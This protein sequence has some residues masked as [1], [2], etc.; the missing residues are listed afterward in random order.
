[1]PVPPASPGAS[2]A[3]VASH[4]GT[5]CWPVNETPSRRNS[6]PSRAWVADTLSGGP[7]SRQAFAASPGD[8]PMPG[9]MYRNQVWCPY[10]G[11][12]VVLC[13][14]MCGQM[15]YVNRRAQLVAAKLSSQPDSQDPQVQLD[16]LHAFD[17]VA[18]ELA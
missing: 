17:A 7:D 15:I 3:M 16:T 9:G 12:N 18:C 13:L 6:D 4:A 14:G 5:T 1:M 8:N 10:P 11:S 2:K